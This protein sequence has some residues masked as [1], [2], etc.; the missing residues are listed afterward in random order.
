MQSGNKVILNTAILY[1]KMAI[2]IVL[3]L[4]S[5]RLILQALVVEYYCLYNLISGI[6]SMLSFLTTFYL[7][8]NL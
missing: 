4:Y 3:G 5:T 1:I 6:V 2:S 8:L 7:K